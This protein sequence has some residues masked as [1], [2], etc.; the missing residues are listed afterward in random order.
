MNYGLQL[1][2]MYQYWFIHYT[3]LTLL[4]S[5][6]SSG[7]DWVWSVWKLCTIFAIFL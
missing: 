1:I 2:T 6:V 4:M 3:K 5:D 7:D